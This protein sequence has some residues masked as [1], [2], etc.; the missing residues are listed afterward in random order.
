MNK[1]KIMWQ[2]IYRMFNDKYWSGTLRNVPVFTKE[3]KDEKLGEFQ[4]TESGID[5]ILLATNQD[6]TIRETMGVLLH[7]MCHVST[8]K[9]Y[10][11]HVEGHGIEWKEEMKRVGFIGNISELTDGI[12]FF[13]DEDCRNILNEYNT[14][15]FNDE[16]R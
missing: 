3:L 6:L 2:Y 7:E 16:S 8:L 9:N 10:G 5:S 13:T 4:F 1:D 11:F 12:D 14:R 15:V